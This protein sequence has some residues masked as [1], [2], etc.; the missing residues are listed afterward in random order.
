M[1]NIEPYV[2]VSSSFVIIKLLKFTFLYES[3]IAFVSLSLV[4]QFT[5]KCILSVSALSI[6]FWFLVFA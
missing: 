4:V 5:T 2:I 6:R 1:L 3:I